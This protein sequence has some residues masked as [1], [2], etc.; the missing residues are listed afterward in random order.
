MFKNYLTNR[1]QFVVYDDMKSTH[2]SISCGV[3]QGSVLGPTLFL[4]YINDLPNSS[5][6]FNFRL[7]AD[8]SNLFHTFKL[9]EGNIDLA[10][11]SRNLQAVVSWCNSNKLTI[12]VN[13]N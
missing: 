1:K 2:K 5:K 7:F 13:T 9:N 11:V 3:P 12:N 10:D 8:D 6:Y 4:A